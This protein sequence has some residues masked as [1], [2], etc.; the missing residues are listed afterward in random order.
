MASG[1]APPNMPLWIPWSRVRTVST[2]RI[3]PRNVVVSAGS[4]TA[5]LVESARTIASA[6]SFSPCRSRMVPR[7]SEPIS[8]SPSTK[9]VTPTGKR[10]GV[11]AQGRD[12]GHHAGLVVGDAAGVDPAVTLGR[13]ERRAVPVGLGPGGLDVVVGVQHDGRCALGPVDVSDDGGSADP[14]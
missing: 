3:M 9:T 13:L 4:P 10:A 8:S 12:V 2:T 7:L 5:Q 1:T 6:R 11:G 14:P